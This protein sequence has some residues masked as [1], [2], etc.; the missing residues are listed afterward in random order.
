MAKDDTS[1]KGIRLFST[2]P[3]KIAESIKHEA[4]AA[5]IDDKKKL[6]N[7]AKKARVHANKRQV[8]TERVKGAI[9][10]TPL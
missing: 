1:D 5:K 4:S 2:A 9:Q 6:K 3:R 10:K 8:W 7:I